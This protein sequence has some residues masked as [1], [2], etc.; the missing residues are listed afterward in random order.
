MG[1]GTYATSMPHSTNCASS[2]CRICTE[3]PDEGSAGDAEGVV[4]ARVLVSHVDDR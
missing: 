2:W 3:V 4:R 1:Q